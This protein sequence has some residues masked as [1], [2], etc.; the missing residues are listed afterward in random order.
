MAEK[1]RDIGPYSR[2]CVLAKLD[3]R[4]REARVL[5]ETRAALE[6]HCGGHGQLSATQDVLIERACWLTLRVS[7]LDVKMAA[8]SAFT[9]HDSRHY[10]AWSNALS[11][12]MK[13]LG[14]P[15][16]ATPRGRTTADLR[17]QVRQATGGPVRIAETLT[18]APADAYKA[19]IEGRAPPQAGR[20]CD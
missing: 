3:Q 1:A 2:P 20:S 8:G 6:A 17:R 7:Q 13:H 15:A 10:L 18:I 5:R 12:I 16:A 14:K 19:M 9:D 11:R 4:T